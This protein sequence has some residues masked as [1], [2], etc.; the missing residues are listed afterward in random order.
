MLREAEVVVG[1]EIDPVRR[2]EGSR[3]LG[4]SNPEQARGDARLKPFRLG[5]GLLAMLVEKGSSRQV[6]A[7]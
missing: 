2:V 4:V 5:H 1:A 3:E 7:L 6:V